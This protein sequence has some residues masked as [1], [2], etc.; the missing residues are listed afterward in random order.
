[1]S[2][3]KKTNFLTDSCSS[4]ITGFGIKEQ[5]YYSVPSK[6]KLIDPNRNYPAIYDFFSNV[7][8]YENSYDQMYL[9]Y[10]KCLEENALLAAR[11]LLYIRDAR[12]G[13]G[14]KSIFHK[15]I[16]ALS[17]DLEILPGIINLI[18]EVGRFDD[19]LISWKSKKAMEL[20]L[21]RYIDG[22]NNPKEIGL[23]CKWAPLKGVWAYRLR[24]ALGLTR[25]QYRKFIV[26]NRSTVEQLMCKNEWR[27]I[28]YS[29]VP[30]I[31]HNN[32]R[33]AFIRHDPTG[34]EQYITDLSSGETKINN[35]VEPYELSRKVAGATELEKKGIDLTFDS[36]ENVFDETLNLLMMVDV[37]PSM[38]C[39]CSVKS[40]SCKDI[41][42]SLGLYGSFKNNGI[43]K[44]Y[45]CTFSEKPLFINYSSKTYSSCVEDLEKQDWGMR[46][47]IR[48]AFD[49]MYRIA[50]SKKCK[51]SDIPDAIIILSDMSFNDGV[52]LGNN[53]Y[54]EFSKI[55]FNYN[56]TKVPK[57]IFWN[58]S[59][60]DSKANVS[61]ETK[62]VI[63][64]SGFSKNI[65]G[66]LNEIITSP[67]SFTP[68]K[69]M[70]KIL[71]SDRYSF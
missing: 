63:E 21:A 34:Y 25:K 23:A 58:L 30:S 55:A 2:I 53:Q 65:M 28:E 29:N 39:G 27:N 40:L 64:I 17:N 19:L 15:I 38:N 46:T 33:K 59:V 56:F 22:F 52:N 24:T 57:V 3:Q 60:Q 10:K 16:T 68:M 35:K 42:M 48:S 49:E 66:S 47:N 51:N 32:Y 44:G 6:G 69:A 67:E 14:R 70:M 12:E 36:Y 37:S 4:S 61:S 41:A 8:K 43:F 11:L 71:L 54:K 7:L 20:A 18:P 62:G 9:A 1:M 13:L 45:V 5:I 26:S 50:K 31:A